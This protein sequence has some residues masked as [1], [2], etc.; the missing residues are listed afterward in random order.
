MAKGAGALLLLAGGA[1]LL[2]VGGK[3]K[4]PPGP[5]LSDLPG[6][7]ECPDGSVYDPVTET[8]TPIKKAPSRPVTR[9]NPPNPAGGAYD[10]KY[11]DKSQGGVGAAGI[12][13]HFKV[14]GY[15]V[16]QN[17]TPLNDP[18]PDGKLGG[19]DDVPN[20]TVRQFQRDYNSVSR[21]GKTGATIVGIKV[22]SNMGTLSTDG[23]VGPKT[24]NALK[25]A[26]DNG[27]APAPVWFAMKKQAEVEGHYK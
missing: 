3:K 26:T 1:A 12:R 27:I 23:Y 18:G 14:M 8:C 25:F 6:A 9:T 2:L 20:A 5:V 21:Y 4:K 24:L 11:W 17:D 22:P 13:A 19:G 10:H 7:D 15:G 16:A